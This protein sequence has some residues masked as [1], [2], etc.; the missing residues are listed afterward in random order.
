MRQS[1]RTNGE[2]EY[3]MLKFSAHYETAK[4]TGDQSDLLGKFKQ[5]EF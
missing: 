3:K 2:E 1:L 4:F 5:E